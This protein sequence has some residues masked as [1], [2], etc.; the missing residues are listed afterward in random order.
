MKCS[1][2]SFRL[3]GT[4]LHFSMS[5]A[6]PCLT[7]ANGVAIPAVGTGCAYGDWVGATDFPGFL[8]E[9][10][11]RGT[12]LAF[13]LGARHFDMAY[14]YATHRQVS[15]VLSHAFMDG[16]IVRE[17]V[18]LTTKIAH[19]P[20]PPHIALNPAFTV[21][22]FSQDVAG[23]V[24]RHFENS[25]V[26]LGVGFVDLLLVHW[27][28]HFANTD[29]DAARQARL[30]IWAAVENIYSKKQARAIGVCNFT[31]EH[32]EEI[33][34]SCSVKPMINQFEIHP[35]CYDRELVAFCKSHRIVVEAYAPFASGAFG[36]LKDPVLLD[37]ANQHQRSV[38][39]VILRWLFEKGCVVLPKSSNPSRL[40]ENRSFFDFSLSPEQTEKIDGLHPE[41]TAARRSCPDPHSIL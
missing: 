3:I 13:Q 38:G 15:N 26:D 22:F 17:D 39:Q 12:Q 7:L 21:D 32:L 41:G 19:P 18:F 16:T 11:W 40:K 29:S 31:K 20:A 2:L 28:G 25:L 4:S 24:T 30:K 6:T 8:P 37:I 10:A 35:Y 14:V 1:I 36:L 27:P 9:N 33:M 5:V 23:Q 34:Q